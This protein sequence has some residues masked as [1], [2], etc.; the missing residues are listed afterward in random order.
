MARCSQDRA[1]WEKAQKKT[2]SHWL[3]NCS[4]KVWCA[5]AWGTRSREVW[6]STLLCKCHLGIPVALGKSQLKAAFASKPVHVF[7]VFL[8]FFYAPSSHFI[9]AYMSISIFV[10]VDGM[11][12]TCDELEGASAFMEHLINEMTSDLQ[13][14]WTGRE[15]A[16]QWVFLEPLKWTDLPKTLICLWEVRI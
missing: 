2:E 12:V 4:S 5:R 14:Q 7:I 9:L 3:K 15:Q 11:M 1:S 16:R 8:S 6:T 13:H 10:W